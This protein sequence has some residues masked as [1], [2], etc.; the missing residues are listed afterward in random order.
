M[1]DFNFFDS[2]ESELEIVEKQLTENIDTNIDILHDASVHLIHAGGK[3]LRPAFA[4]LT[5]RLF[6]KDINDVIPM[7]VA[8]ELVHMATLVHDDVIDNSVARRGTIT[9]KKGWGNRVSIYAGNYILAKSLMLVS[10]YKRNDLLEIMA[11][12]SIKICEGEITQM[13]GSF[14]VDIGLKNY[15]RRIERKTALLIAVS[16]KLGA[17][18]S[19]AP[20]KDVKDIERYGHFLGMAFQVT[21]DILDLVA[22]EEVLGKPVGSDIRQG[23]ITLPALY[24]MNN[25]K[26]SDELKLALTSPEECE[27]NTG[28]IIDMIQDSDGIDYAYYVSKRYAIKAQQQLHRLPDVPEK[29]VLHDIANYILERDY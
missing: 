2:I 15:L 21:D 29:K 7:A 13:F 10:G 27:N 18:I 22:D 20:A 9:V 12:T 28:K 5:A 26:H 11:E 14:N 19:N 6:Q 17:L 16:C 4:L 23:V 25:S 24:A 3:R 1:S 8:L